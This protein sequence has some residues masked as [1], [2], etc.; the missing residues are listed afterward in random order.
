MS[1]HLL[2]TYEDFFY[3]LPVKHLLLFVVK[4]SVGMTLLLPLMKYPPDVIKN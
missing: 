4:M 3:A 2:N 1:V